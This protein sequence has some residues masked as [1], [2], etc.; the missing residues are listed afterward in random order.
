MLA[1]QPLATAPLAWRPAASTPVDPGPTTL[2][3]AVRKLLRDDAAVFAIVGER[4]RYARSGRSDPEPRITYT[5]PSRLHGRD[6]DGPDDTSDARVRV[7]VWAA[8]TPSGSIEAEALAEAVRL[9][10]DG[11]S[12]WVGEVYVA[13]IDHAVSI[14]LPEW[15]ADGSGASTYQIAMDF[16][17]DHRAPQPAHGG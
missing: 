9:A 6:L 8:G 11:F 3:D 16:M 15:E 2:R 14:D 13:S 10:L 1:G 7:S 4:I 12:G 5:V 17:V